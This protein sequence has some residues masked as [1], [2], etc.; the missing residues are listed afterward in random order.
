M[1]QGETETKIRTIAEENGV[2]MVDLHLG[3]SRYGRTVNLFVDTL[4]GVTI[5]QLSRVHSAVHSAIPALFDDASVVSLQVS[6]PGLD[7]PL[8]FPWQYVRHKGRTV[9]VT[10]ATD[11]G[12]AS[13]CGEISDATEDEVLLTLKGQSITIPFA[14]IERALIQIKI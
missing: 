13:V 10:Y 7:A 3:N 2:K 1:I 5:E 8:L 11:T 14:R 6:S 12:T 9:N 4:E